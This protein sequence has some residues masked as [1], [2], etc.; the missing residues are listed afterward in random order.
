MKGELSHMQMNVKKSEH[1]ILI[2]MI[3]KIENVNKKWM[4]NKY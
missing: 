3:E 4:T 1:N 2:I